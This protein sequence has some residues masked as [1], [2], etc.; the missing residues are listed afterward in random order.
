MEAG[1]FKSSHKW[2][3]LLMWYNLV[4]QLHKIL[5]WL[6]LLWKLLHNGL[7]LWWYLIDIML[8]QWFISSWSYMIQQLTY[9]VLYM[10]CR[11]IWSWR[12]WML[13]KRNKAVQATWRTLLYW[14]M[15]TSR[16][17]QYCLVPSPIKILK[18][19]IAWESLMKV[20]LF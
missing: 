3:F 20:R 12:H 6:I 13:S 14:L 17:K 9:D 19:I 1:F 2:L 4:L 7:T 18:F 15:E 11:K 10:Y 8:L 16:N 5:W